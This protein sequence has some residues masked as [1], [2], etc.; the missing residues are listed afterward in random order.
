[1]RIRGGGEEEGRGGSGGEGL[2]TA[3]LVDQFEDF[4]YLRCIYQG[5]VGDIGEGASAER[6]GW[7]NRCF[8]EFE[9]PM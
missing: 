3:V 9:A 8:I 4:F 5:T 2:A 1:M 7:E 6:G